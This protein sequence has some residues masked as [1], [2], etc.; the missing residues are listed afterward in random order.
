MKALKFKH[1]IVDPNN[2]RDPHCKAAGDIDGDGNPDVLSAS[3]KDEGLFWY[4]YPDWTKHKI[5]DGS[6]TTDMKVADLDGNGYQD[7]IIPDK[8]RL[9][10]FKNPLAQ[11]GNPETDP[12]EVVQVGAVGAHDVRVCDVNNNGTLDL[13][14]R[15]QS[16]FNYNAGN[17]IRIWTQKSPTEWAHHAFDCPHGEGLGIADFDGDGYP[18]VAI[19]GRWY[20]NPGADNQAEWTEHFYMPETYFETHWTNGD[21]VVGIGDFNG[22]GRPDIVL[23]P[24]EG[25]GILA[26]YEAPEDP[27]QPNWTEHIMETE[28]DHAH[29]IAVGDLDKDGMPDLVVAKMHQA[30]APQ[31]VTI[32]YNVDNASSWEKQVVTETGSHNISL[33][34]IGN[35]GRLDIYGA[36]WNNRAPTGGAI[37]LWLNEG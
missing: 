24:A 34:D 7:V 2:P 9:I 14:T 32:Y 36:N 30:S 20:R 11:G 12:W 19:G 22:D 26:W 18:D 35:T 15:Q 13:I 16:G 3:A 21:V 28:L 37:E 33:V 10:I 25:S 27:T 23:S 5:A 29:G 8:N 31:T 17:C 6:F 4:R 1:I